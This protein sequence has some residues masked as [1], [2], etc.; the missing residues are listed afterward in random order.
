MRIYV[1]VIA[2]SSQN[3]IEKISNE[4]YK[5]WTS[6]LPIKGQANEAII[7]NLAEF[8]SVSRNKIKIVGGKT[9]SRKIIDIQI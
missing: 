4:D 9:A 5:A 3:R 7:K 1:K 6:A 8:F 2:N